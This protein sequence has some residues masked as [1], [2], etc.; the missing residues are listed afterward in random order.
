MPAVDSAITDFTPA[1]DAVSTELPVE[2]ARFAGAF[3]PVCACALSPNEAVAQFRVISVF[4]VHRQPA[5]RR[6]LSVI[7]A[8]LGSGYLAKSKGLGRRA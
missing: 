8:R 3:V 4:K 2:A 5:I 6:W 7:G 1:A